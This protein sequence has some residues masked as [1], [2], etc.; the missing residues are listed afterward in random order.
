MAASTLDPSSSL[1]EIVVAQPQAAALFERLRLDYCCG[2]ADTLADACARRGLDAA[3]VGALLEAFIHE[4]RDT[5]TMAAHDVARAS[6]TELCDH[7]VVAH[8]GPLRPAQDRIAHLLATVVRVHGRDHPSLI[9]LERCFAT[10]ATEL[11]EH[12]RIEEETIFPACRALDGPGGAAFDDH[13][14]D[15]MQD[16]HAATGDAL[17][18][19]RELAGDFDGRH[20]LCST[21]RTLLTELRAFEL[22]LHQHVHEENNLL[23]PRVRA[24]VATA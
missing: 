14:L 4:S 9:D 19:I 21:H 7:I 22:D 3:T 18:A 20:A 8:H 1:A 13:L 5:E 23:F 24:L 2:G 17:L 11:A 12:I 15:L 6:I 16:D 10:L